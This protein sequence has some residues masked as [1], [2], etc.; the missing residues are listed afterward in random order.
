MESE[1]T[2]VLQTFSRKEAFERNYGLISLDE[3][4]KL[5]R[6][7]VVIAG[8]GG[9]G[10]L[11]AHTLARLGI[12]RFRITDPDTFSL[13]NINRQIGATI[14][15]VGQ[16]KA[17]VTAEMIRSI[18]SEATVEVVEG[19]LTAENTQAFVRDAALVVDGLDFFAMGARRHLFAAAWSAKVPALTAAPL[20]F[21]GTL[22]VFA[23]SGMSFDQ[24]FD[25]HDNQEAF[26]QLVNFAVGLAPAALHV[27]YMDLGSVNPATG[28]SPSSIVG[29]QLAASLIGA[30]AVRILLGRGELRLA[31]CYLQFDAYRQKLRAGRVRS[32][33]RGWVQ[34]LKRIVVKR[35]LRALGLDQT[36][37]QAQSAQG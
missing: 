26:E 10:G 29:C 9:V 11:H 32:G 34:R 33:N 36:L 12:G 16:N 6:S 21:S 2:R 27:P 3:Q 25:L 5:H 7:L 14:H 19:G 30:E 23:H 13:A 28:R 37:R 31:P 15:S 22:H 1:F 4:E 35:R 18:N 24:Y 20:G 17:E 8:C